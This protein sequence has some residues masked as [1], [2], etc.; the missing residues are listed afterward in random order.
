MFPACVMIGF[1][2]VIDFELFYLIG[3]LVCLAIGCLN[4]YIVQSRE[5]PLKI[6]ISEEGVYLLMKKGQ[7]PQYT[8]AEITKIRKVTRAIRGNQRQEIYFSND[9]EPLKLFAFAMYL[10]DRRFSDRLRVTGQ[11]WDRPVKQ[12][13]TI[14][15]KYVSNLT[16]GN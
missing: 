1:Y 5:V 7:K 2:F 14:F 8:W 16:N 10:P 6:Y 3:L 12:A 11:T 13:R 9:S 4:Y 15:E